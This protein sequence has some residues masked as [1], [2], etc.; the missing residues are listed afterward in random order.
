MKRA[1]VAALA[2]IAFLA[3]WRTMTRPESVGRDFSAFY[4]G[5]DAVARGVDPYRATSIDVCEW[6]R[7]VAGF[8]SVPAGLALPAPLPPYDL[9][10]FGLLS[11]FPYEIA[12]I[13]FLVGIVLALIVTVEAMRRL[14]GLTR[15]VLWLVLA[16]MDG[17]DAVFLGE[18]APFAVAA[19]AVG[20]VLLRDGRPRCAAMLVALSLCEP[21]VGIASALALFVCVP[22]TR[23]LLAVSALFLY[24]VSIVSVGAQ[25]TLEYVS[26][27][28][29]AHAFSEVWSTRQ[30]SLTSLLHAF[31]VADGTALAFGTAS[32]A[33]MLLAGIAVARRL[34]SRDASDPMIVALPAAFVLLG[35]I[36]IHAIQMPAALPAA[37]V[38]Y[39]RTS[40]RHRS[41]IAWATI[42]LAVPWLG[43][44]P[45][46]I[47]VPCE[48]ALVW[49]LALRFAAASPRVAL[50][51]ALAAGCYAYG[52]EMG[53]GLGVAYPTTE[54]H[55]AIGATDLAEV[56][57]GEHIRALSLVDP[58]VYD[59]ARLPEWISIATLVAFIGFLRATILPG[60]SGT[61]RGRADAVS[62]LRRFDAAPPTAIATGARYGEGTA[63]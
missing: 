31:G 45:F 8:F 55:T 40:G 42:G 34:S 2:A 4:C 30:L 20:M 7:P 44:L 41:I 12:T 54:I 59:L 36:F 46:G 24:A 48:A 63:G 10:A 52:L 16:P 9:A 49:L 1:I 22:A 56:S 57:W 35:G 39:S 6:T 19:L 47:V 13:V 27:V 51:A 28:L 11:R 17:F 37:L 43:F 60:A 50:L 62:P 61:S 3:C 26:D 25:T 23:V 32:Y 33:V 15:T 5:G 18:I 14:T 53:V 58:F 21:H 29:P 38:A